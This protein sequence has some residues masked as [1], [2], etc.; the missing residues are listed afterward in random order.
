MTIDKKLKVQKSVQKQSTKVKNKTKSKYKG[1]SG[2]R[3]VEVDFIN[4]SMGCN[5]ICCLTSYAQ[6]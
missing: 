6:A 3:A 1:M 4:W 2:N 5:S